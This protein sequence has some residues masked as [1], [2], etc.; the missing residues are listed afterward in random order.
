M[1]I[2][3]VSSMKSYA[4]PTGD[5]AS[6]T[7]LY[8]LP[9]SIGLLAVDLCE[10][11]PGGHTSLHSHAEEHVL[12]ILSGQGEITGEGSTVS[13]TLRPEA[14]VY[15][16]PR[17]PHVL[18][19]TGSQLLRV[20]VSTSLLVR[21]DR[22]LGVSASQPQ[23][24]P[25][26]ATAAQPSASPQRPATKERT[27][28]PA[29]SAPAS[30]ASAPPSQQPPAPEAT[31]VSTPLPQ[32]DTDDEVRPAPDLSQL[33][34]RGSD[35]VG[36]PRSERRRS[37][38]E[39]EPVPDAD[40]ASAED[41]AAQADEDGEGKSDLMELFVAF[42]GG[43][44][45]N[46][47]Q[48]YGSYLVQSPGRKPVIK[49]V[50]FGDNYTNNQAEYDTFISCVEYI[51][52]RLTATGRTP[53]NMQLDI[54]SDSDLLVNQVLGNYKVKEPGLRKRHD[55]VTA[56]LEQFADWRIEWHPREESVRLLGH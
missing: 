6:L 42:D 2:R 44:R 48:G 53:Q 11:Q 38:P 16:G 26:E 56:L 36:A 47:G 40:T 37:A 4:Q 14:V 34:K 51:V 7:Q 50:E 15:L 19:N 13:A 28:S 52:A 17:E 45:G 5:S 9:S 12:F 3:D 43:S 49:R 18:R 27:P 33:M 39:P 54:R 10:I 41:D 20:L 29:A 35:L 21:S 32:I 24:V 30:P 1:E 46:P 31:S 8:P 23:P 55:Q 25:A 22:M